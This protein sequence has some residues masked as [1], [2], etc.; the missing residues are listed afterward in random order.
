MA[1]STATFAWYAAEN[2]SVT[3]QTLSVSATAPSAGDIRIIAGA[4]APADWATAP[5]TAIAAAADKT[6][7]PAFYNG[8]IATTGFATT[9]I[10]TVNYKT[11]TGVKVFDVDSIG[12]AEYATFK[13]MI[14]NLGTTEATVK[15]ETVTGLD[16]ALSCIV[17]NGT[18]VIWADV[19]QNATAPTAADAVDGTGAYAT[20]DGSITDGTVT[21]Q[22]GEESAVVID[23]CIFLDGVGYDEDAY[24]NGTKEWTVTSIVFKAQ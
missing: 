13:F 18:N 10:K 19:Q 8:T 22:P 7:D 23:V 16:P 20:T 4:T 2:T 6:L 5:Y 3:A 24:N 21:I 1:L 17:A 14:A 11:D 15:V 12:Q 9:S